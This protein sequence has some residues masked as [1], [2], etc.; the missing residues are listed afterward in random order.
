M[1]GEE[2]R[3]VVSGVIILL[4]E[5]ETEGQEGGKVKYVNETIAFDEKDLKNS[6]RKA[7]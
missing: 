3:N 5:S 4:Q 1:A 2:S 6:R 7:V